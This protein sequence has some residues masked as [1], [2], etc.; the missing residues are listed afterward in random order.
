MVKSAKANVRQGHSAKS[1]LLKTLKQNDSVQILGYTQNWIHV[2][3]HSG[4]AG[5]IYKSLL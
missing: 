3:D 1:T 4:T 2:R 5:Y